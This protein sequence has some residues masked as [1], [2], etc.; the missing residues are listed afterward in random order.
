M[1]NLGTRILRRHNQR[2]RKKSMKPVPF[3]TL[4]FVETIMAEFDIPEAN[5]K[6]SCVLLRD[7]LT[8][9]ISETS[10]SGEQD[11]ARL[12]PSIDEENMYHRASKVGEPMEQIPLRAGLNELAP[13]EDESSGQKLLEP[14][15]AI[16]EPQDQVS[17][18]QEFPKDETQD[19][20]FNFGPVQSV[21]APIPSNSR[22]PPVDDIRLTINIS[23]RHHRK[24]KLEALLSETTIGE[25]VEAWIDKEIPQ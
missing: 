8:P 14:T 16:A 11:G 13:R 2:R 7:S 23:R 15:P 22:L 21:A 1:D 24:I 25:M 10:D 17:A 12:R 4:K 6:V 5:A 20:F 18:D 19:D 3:D 9:E